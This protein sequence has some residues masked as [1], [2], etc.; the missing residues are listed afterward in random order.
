M[1]AVRSGSSPGFSY[2]FFS[3][4]AN[5]SVNTWVISKSTWAQES[6]HNH[7]S[8]KT[9]R[10]VPSSASTSAQLWTSASAGCVMLASEIIPSSKLK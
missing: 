9:C 5:S 1:V 3:L 6:H 8:S 4:G 7:N 2:T 10:V